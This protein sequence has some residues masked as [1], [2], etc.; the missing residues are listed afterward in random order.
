[1]RDAKPMLAGLV[2]LLAAGA[3]AAPAYAADATCAPAPA[4]VRDLDVPR[5][6]DDAQGA[7]VDPRLAA[8]HDAAVAPLTAFLR[9]VTKDADGAWRAG[10]DAGRRR[11]ATCAL[12]WL[13][14]WARGGA[15]LGTM[16]SRQAEYQRKFDLAGVALAY[17]KVRPFATPAER[18]AIE[19]WLITFADRARAFFDD[20]ARARNN[21]WY[22]LGLGL[23]AVAHA[24]DSAAHWSA[25][26]AV[27]ADAARDID[28]AG[29]LAHELQRGPRA[30]FYHV[31]AVVPLVVM[32]ELAARRGEDWY[33]LGGGAL[34]RLVATTHGGLRAP[35]TFAAHA[36]VAQEKDPPT[37][38]AWLP[39]YLARFPDRLPAP[40][41]AV[42]DGH[43]WLG[44]SSKALMAALDAVRDG[45]QGP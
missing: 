32:T 2:L 34:H 40:H 17:L 25:A 7:K 35:E 29:L 38:A 1:M 43:R 16:A 30:L 10:S 39:L 37:R 28:A 18:A 45:R 9:Q 23:A 36:G 15:W 19:S 12:A 42:A 6:Y 27:M 3:G 21:H 44:G 5:F 31:F 8:A 13:S 41:P 22:W 11:S 26:R 20:P 4:A 14:A 24:T 33:T